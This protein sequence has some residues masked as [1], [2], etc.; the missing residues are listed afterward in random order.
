[1]LPKARPARKSRQR[2][3]FRPMKLHADSPS[4]YH[5]VTA[6][7]PGYVAVDGRRHERS[8][9]L[10]PDRIDA[11]WGPEN[12][13][14]LGAEHFAPLAQLDCDVLLLG[15]GVR[16][17]FPAPALM[18]ALIEAGRGVEAMDTAAAC[19]T[20]NILVAEGR[21]VAA[22]LVVEQAPA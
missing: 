6:H 15:T 8:L 10:L 7:G 4:T 20:Y 11:A 17:R 12:F 13:A 2:L 22:A 19:R 16:Q 18:R 9:L 3:I 21:K 1:M 5:V 14:R